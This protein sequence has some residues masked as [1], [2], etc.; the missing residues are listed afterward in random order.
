MAAARVEAPGDRL[1]AAALAGRLGLRERCGDDGGAYLRLT[2][3]VRGEPTTIGGLRR[4]VDDRG[5]GGGVELLALRLALPLLGLEAE[6][7]YAFA[8][9]ASARPHLLLSATLSGVPGSP[10]IATVI[11]DLAPR[12]ELAVNPSYVEAVYAPLEPALAELERRAADDEGLALVELPRRRRAS[13]SPF[14][15]AARLVGDL[16]IERCVAPVVERWCALAELRLADLHRPAPT[17]RERRLRAAL[18]EPRGDPLWAEVARLCEPAQAAAV[19]R[20]I[21]GEA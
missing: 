18:V 15:V 13:A 16:A 9:A 8:P 4:F 14:A 2:S 7:L 17:E 1:G 19:T 20:V 10:G 12:V 6:R 21:V 3:S 11:A 5:E